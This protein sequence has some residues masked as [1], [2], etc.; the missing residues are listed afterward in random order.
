[1]KYL[2]FILFALLWSNLSF[3]QEV[4]LGLPIGHTKEIKSIK[5]SS[6]GKYLLTASLDNSVL[7]WDIASGKLLK[8]FNH[9][10]EGVLGAI[11]SPD[12][13]YILSYSRDAKA[14]L[15]DIS[16]EKVIKTFEGHT[17]WVTSAD[18]SSD[19]RFLI[20]ASEDK[21]A[22]MWDVSSGKLIY[23]LDR[24]IFYTPEPILEAEGMTMRIPW[25]GK[26]AVPE[27]VF[28]P[29]MKSLIT[30]SGDQFIKIWDPIS[31]RRIL[32]LEGP[33]LLT[34]I[35]LSNN[36]KLIACVLENH[37]VS[38]WDITKGKQLFNF[39]DVG[40]INSVKF[41]HNSERLIISSAAKGVKVYN[42]MN[43]NQMHLLECSSCG[44]NSADFSQDGK[45]IVSAS[46][47]NTVDLWD[48]ISGRLLFRMEGH[49]ANVEN[50]LFGPENFIV[51]TSFDKSIR[52][53]ST[54]NGQVKSILKSRSEY[55]FEVG[56][57]KDMNSL[58]EVHK[59]GVN[60]WDLKSGKHLSAINTSNLKPT[61]FNELLGGRE[62]YIMDENGDLL[63]VFDSRI[64]MFHEVKLSSDGK[65]LLTDSGD[66]IARLWDV[67]TGGLYKELKSSK[68]IGD[69]YFCCND[70][71]I[72]AFHFDEGNT[73][74][75]DV[76]SGKEDT[77]FF[78][79]YS[80]S[81]IKFLNY[82][83]HRFLLG[84]T[85]N[86][87]LIIKDLA[88]GVTSS[89]P[90]SDDVRLATVSYS[91]EKIIVLTETN[92]IV[93]IDLMYGQ[94]EYQYHLEDSTANKIVS[95]DG[96]KV[97]ILNKENKVSVVDMRSGR[98][99]FDFDEFE[100][101]IKRIFFT[102]DGR[103]VA[104][105]D[106]KGAIGLIDL[107]LQKRIRE[108]TIENDLFTHCYLSNDLNKIYTTTLRGS[109]Q[110]W[111]IGSD[112]PVIEHYDFDSDP[113]KWVHLHPSGL[114]DASPEA[115]ELMYWTKGLEVIEFAQLKDRYWVPGLWEKVMK[116]EPLPDARNMQE[117]KLQPEIEMGEMKDGKIPVTLT[118]REGGYG[119]VSILIN[120]KEIQADARGNNFDKS[121][122]TQTIWV[123]LKDHPNL[124][125]G[126]N[127]IAVK[128]SSEDGFVVG[129][130]VEKKITS[131]IETTNP[132]F[133]AIVIGTGKYTN[134]SINL[135]YPEKDAQSMSTALKLGSEQL[136]GKENTH[137]YTLT[138]SSTERPT[139]EK[140]KSVFTEIGKTAKSSDVVLVYLSGHGIAWGGDQGDFYYVT[141]DATAANAEA[142]NDDVLRKNHSISTAEFTEYL[143]AIPANK[144]VMIIDACSSG[145]AVENLMASRDIDVS[146]I[147]AIDRMKDRTGMFVIS[148]SS[149]DAVS[150][151]ASRYGQGLLTYSILQAMKG[152]SLR[153]G[154]FFD[155]N[156]LLNY[157]RENVPK[158]AAGIGGIQTPQLLVPKGG[159]FD[160]GKVDSLSKIQIPLSSI[161][162]VFVRTTFVDAETFTDEMNLSK[163]IDDE[164]N[165]I[166]MR[167]KDG[168]L[169]FLDTREFPDA[170]R[171]SGGYT[172]SN[173]TIT[174]KLKIKGPKESEHILTAPTKEELIEKIVEIVEGLK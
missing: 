145:K 167:G 29:D 47:D 87:R 102:E 69:V 78:S 70:S 4:K 68:S 44:S 151:E 81:P 86:N 14:F 111:K 169:V 121:K 150:Y 136:F 159:S 91:Q 138:T 41:D 35:E 148:G 46:T 79:S 134:S 171:L 137:I 157:A 109:F 16:T 5:L 147:K 33:D 113:N 97:I 124:Q 106:E 166:A 39:E 130:P 155:V 6:N 105:L 89:L 172:Q 50:V 66:G 72:L 93:V 8:T 76:K 55:N 75:W 164:M 57:A 52:I 143:K 140:I 7:M 96:V 115:M 54:K 108:L 107:E 26:S 48:A 61:I 103:N 74:I 128:A 65:M 161:K 21:T 144:Q 146:S 85:K 56:L 2:Y 94:L 15:W 163:S 58:A 88:K 71:K 60:V 149:A 45:F 25:T 84:I 13:K 43:G 53:W 24:N 34:M 131:S 67:Q 11:F 18:F 117:L 118:K 37:S 162:P 158:L 152:A 62:S 110:I 64:H 49:E 135:K 31:G 59:G 40:V 27:A 19:G 77:L 141:T 125:N 173:G 23:K 73:V 153:D 174:L 122:D 165:Q 142:Y 99:L 28:S 22:C 1:M 119:K 160:I 123:D 98:I 10:T 133:Y 12:E 30:A 92:T 116:G 95:Y 112:V 120:G 32:S 17:S 3:G 114:F 129:R 63:Q 126:E 36:G 168:A 170:Y 139:K 101:K 104:I 38:V 154:E 82:V 42:L 20:T 83:N 156:M 51:S 127:S 132:H 80:N 100:N 90:I 9:H